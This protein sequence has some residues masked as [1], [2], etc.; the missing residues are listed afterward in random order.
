MRTDM[1]PLLIFATAFSLASI[2]LIWALISWFE[3]AT[4]AF[5]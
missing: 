1:A 3:R 2:A 5:L 4:A